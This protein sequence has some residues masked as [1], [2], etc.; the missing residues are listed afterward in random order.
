VSQSV[1]I[2]KIIAL[3]I[4][5]VM[6]VL[7]FAQNSQANRQTIVDYTQKAL[8]DK[9]LYEDEITEKEIPLGVM[10][11]LKFSYPEHKLSTAYRGSNGSYKIMLEE[12]NKKIAAFYNS[13]GD[14][15]KL[16][17]HKEELE[18]NTNDNWR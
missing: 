18:E 5:S 1:K 4:I 7:V 12:K 3:I 9:I 16:E 6:P 14:F 17:T 8:E 13:N 10:N 11:S 15:L 2:E